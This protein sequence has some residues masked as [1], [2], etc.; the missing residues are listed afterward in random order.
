MDYIRVFF[1]FF[2]FLFF[3]FVNITKQNK[4]FVGLQ[5]LGK[6]SYSFYLWHLAIGYYTIGFLRKVISSDD[7]VSILSNMKTYFP[8]G[9]FLVIVTLFISFLTYKYIEEFFL[10]KNKNSLKSPLVASE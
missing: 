3:L 2:V 6:V 4:I 9:L 8:I 5:L 10:R 1:C 7:G